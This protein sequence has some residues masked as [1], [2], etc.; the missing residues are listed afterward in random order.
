M[1]MIYAAVMPLLTSSSGGVCA[2]WGGGRGCEGWQSSIAS[3]LRK[4]IL[5]WGLTCQSLCIILCCLPEKGRTDR[6]D[7]REDDSEGQG[8][9]RK[10][11]E[12]VETE[13]I[14]I[15]PLYPYLLQG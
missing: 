7:S 11:N 6:R 15:F 4:T 5:C 13:E 12:S 8:V 10:R 2:W 9:K 3:A 1:A 14:K